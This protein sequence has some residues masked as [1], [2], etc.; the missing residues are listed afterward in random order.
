MN[1]I[2]QFALALLHKWIGLVQRGRFVVL[3]FAFVL[4]AIA[5]SYTINNL[6]INTST[7]DMLSP[8]LPWRKLDI[9]HVKQ[10][11]KISNN[12]NVVIEAETPDQ[13]QD[14]AELLYSKLQEETKVFKTVYYPNGS[15]IF[16]EDGLLF[17]DLDELQDLA[18]E[19]AAMQPF[20][21]QL[22]EDQSI[23][24]LFGMLSKVVDTINDGD[25]FDIKSLLQQINLSLVAINNKRDYRISWHQLMNGEERLKSV[26]KKFIILQPILDF[27]DL[28]PASLAIERLQEITQELGIEEKLGARI[29][30]TGSAALAHEE[31]QTVSRGIEIVTLLAL[32]TVSVILLFG[33]GSIRL[34]VATLLTLIVGLVLTAAFATFAVGEL[35]LISIAFAV[36]YIG[37]GVDFAIHYCLRYREL[38]RQG[39][40]NPDSIETAS[41]NVGSS[42]FL[43]ATT[44]AIGFFAFIPTDYD[45][46]AELGLISGTGIFISLIVTLTFLPAML[47]IFK[48]TPNAI[49]HNGNHLSEKFKTLLLFPFTHARIVSITSALSVLAFIVLLTQIK[50]DHNPLNLQNPAMESVQTAK[51]LITDRTTSPRKGIVLASGK[52][53]AV[54]TANKISRLPLVGEVRWVDDFIPVDQGDKL[55]I[56]EEMGLLLGDLD[57]NTRTPNLE[58]NDRIE[59][60]EKFVSDVNKLASKE[61]HIRLIN[62]Q[63]NITRVLEQLKGLDV[64]QQSQLLVRLENNLLASLPGRMRA[65]Q[66]S[67][68]ADF[69]SLE[70]L[71]ATFAEH[72]YN[73]EDR[74]ILEIYPKEDVNNNGALRKFVKQV[75]AIEPRLIGSPVI[76][77]EASDTVVKAFKQAFSYAFIVITVFL[78]ILL[79]HKK[80]TLLIVSTLV[81]AAI[82]TGGVSVILGIPLNFANVIALPLILGIGVDSGIHILH[83]FRTAM[84][85]DNNLL[86]TSSAQAVLVSALTS[87]CS[88]GNLAFSPHMGTASMG[89]LLTIGIGMTLVC[90]LI[91]LPSLLA[92]SASNE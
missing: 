56:I 28:M 25:T 71:P 2:K 91:V 88:M 62:L 65:L 74:Y 45:G 14:A 81:M 9:E 7:A 58:D 13:A 29:K 61:S 76:N 15:S 87:I 92:A 54:K 36:L 52:E 72:W 39:N 43:C 86:A 85:E 64:Q 53:D 75:Q 12:I 26:Y 32:T 6:R 20:L 69:V 31:L 55:F 21:A 11:P 50:F 1:S 77:I 35:N 33:L 34:V 68:N 24:G 57:V 42:I 19:L 82:G 18:D 60:M 47:C 8:E 30:L 80:D 37:L 51:E 10:F 48:Y 59:A 78:F 17:L 66:D 84:P 73:K 38:R 89:K 63:H 23:R 79:Q 44:T 4:A 70:S 22:T 67:M 40:S 49:N 83:R 90:M 27:G 41:N 16:R 46:V 5:L 3:V